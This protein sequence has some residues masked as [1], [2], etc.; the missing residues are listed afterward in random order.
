[1][2]D[3]E[4]DRASAATHATHAVA[5]VLCCADRVEPEMSGVKRWTEDLPSVSARART[6][7]QVGVVVFQ[8]QDVQS[9]IICGSA[10]GC[11]S[12]VALPS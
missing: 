5:R 1:M 7:V 2:V 6:D 8:D 4:P 3:W 9:E 11:S 12:P 10:T